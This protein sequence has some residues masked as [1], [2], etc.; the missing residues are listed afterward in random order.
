MIGKWINKKENKKLIVFYNGWGMDENILTN[1]N[2]QDFDVYTLNNFN[3]ERPITENFSTYSEKHLIAWSL[4][5]FFANFD[6]NNFNQ[7]IAINGTLNPIDKNEGILPEI[8]DGTIN[9]WNEKNR[10]KFY[11]RICGNTENYQK[12][13]QIAPNRDYNEQKEELIFIKNEIEKANNRNETF[14]KSIC[15]LGDNIFS[16]K[17]QKNFWKNIA[18]EVNIPHFP[19]FFFNSWN[20]IIEL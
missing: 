9:T 2:H 16:V 20:E 5:V 15:G 4:G 7:K 12:F 6:S 17:S 13:L 11:L 8:F 1:F 18:I 3:I 14:N 19:F 10:E